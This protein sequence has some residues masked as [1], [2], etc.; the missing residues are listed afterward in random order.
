[1]AIAVVN[2]LRKSQGEAPL[3]IEEAARGGLIDYIAFPPALVGKY[4][5]YTQADLSAL[6]AAGCDHA[7]A[8]VQAG[9]ASYMQWLGQQV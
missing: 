4:Q 2:T 1:V 7:F 3:S 8:D 5:S 9:V 6:R